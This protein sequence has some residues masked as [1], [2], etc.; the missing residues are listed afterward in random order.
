M[1]TPA[2][3]ATM[4]RYNTWMNEKIYAS[5]AQLPD[6]TRKRDVGAFFKSLHGTLAHLMLGDIVW[7]SRFAPQVALPFDPLRITSLDQIIIPAFEEMRA[8]RVTL[9]AAIATGMATLNQSTLDSELHYTRVNGEKRSL[10]FAIAVTHFFNHQTH[11]RG[12]ATTLLTQLGIDP[13][14]TD[15]VWMVPG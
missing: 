9:D 5:A 4:A 14:E 10:P 11:H 12:Q 13:G 2:Y 7:M 6:E 15:L 3:C 8:A 1:I